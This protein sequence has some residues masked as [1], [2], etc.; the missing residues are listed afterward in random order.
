MATPQLRPKSK[1]FVSRDA[2]S[3]SAALRLLSAERPEEIFPILLEEIVKLGFLRAMILE[4]DFET[5]EVKPTASL[6]C[7]NS[8]LAKFRT[9]LWASENPI[10]SALQNPNPA[11]LHPDHGSSPWYAAVQLAAGR[12]KGSGGGTAW[13]FKIL[14]LP[15]NCNLKSRF[16]PPAGCKP[17]PH[18]CL[19]NSTRTQVKHTW[20]SCAHWPREPTVTSRACS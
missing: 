9:S 19:R 11:I 10:I 2:V 18:W 3:E 12:Q 14:E 1:V 17:T 20:S 7:D 15:G 8:F 4:V 13:R 5:G 6:N 16:V